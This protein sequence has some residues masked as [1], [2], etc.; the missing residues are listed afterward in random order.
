MDMLYSIAELGFVGMAVLFLIA[1]MFGIAKHPQPL[2]VVTI[3]LLW[4]IWLAVNRI[5]LQGGKK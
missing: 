2:T 4:A 3:C 1:D 5:R